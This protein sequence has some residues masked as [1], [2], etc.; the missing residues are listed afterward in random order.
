V[1]APVPQRLRPVLQHQRLERPALLAAVTYSFHCRLVSFYFIR[2]FMAD[3]R[4]S[5]RRRYLS[6]LEIEVREGMRKV[7]SVCFGTPTCVAACVRSIP[8]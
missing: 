6:E 1:L 8:F 4:E 7:R 5:D 3:E 2:L